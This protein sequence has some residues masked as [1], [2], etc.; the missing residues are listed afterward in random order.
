MLWPISHL[1]GLSG[2]LP[3]IFTVQL[4][5]TQIGKLR[6]NWSWPLKQSKTDTQNFILI[7]NANINYLQKCHSR[8]YPQ[9]GQHASEASRKA[10]FQGLILNH[11]KGFPFL[12]L[13]LL[14]KLK[15]AIKVALRSSVQTTWRMIFRTKCIYGHECIFL[16]CFITIIWK[17]E[18]HFG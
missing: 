3:R 5:G 10:T 18:T 16:S 2:K 4:S 14:L 8:G 13:Y 12:K 11:S 1:H 7:W 17:A 6:A 15:A 9:K